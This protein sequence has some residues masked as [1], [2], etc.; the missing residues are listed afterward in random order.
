MKRSETAN[1]GSAD[2]KKIFQPLITDIERM[3]EDQ[4]NLVRVKRLNE[5]HPKA[6]EIKVRRL[7]ACGIK[8][9]DAFQRPS[10][11]SAALD[12]ASISSNAC[13]QPI[14]T[15][16]SS[17]LRMHGRRSSS[18][19]TNHEC[20]DRFIEHQQGCGTEPAARGGSDHFDGF[21]EALW[22]LRKCHVR[23][24]GRRRSAHNDTQVQRKDAGRKGV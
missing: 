14:R 23:R 20:L 9:D 17:N 7:Y 22:R 15:F 10:F 16:R 2:V 13:K 19:T 3:V 6:N 18:K 24:E 4:V 21:H 11:S 1:E 8:A 5:G 12:R